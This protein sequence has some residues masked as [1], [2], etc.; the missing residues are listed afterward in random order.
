M[1]GFV[2][3]YFFKK[4]INAIYGCIDYFIKNE[5]TKMKL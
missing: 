2:R 4:T 3:R 5:T 1:S